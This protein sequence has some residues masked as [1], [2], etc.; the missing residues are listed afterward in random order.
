MAGKSNVMCTVFRNYYGSYLRLSYVIISSI[1]S[2]KVSS[3]ALYEI[4]V[5]LI[6]DIGKV[7]RKGVFNIGYWCCF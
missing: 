5:Y 3:K 1:L 7:S 4:L 2:R 6:L